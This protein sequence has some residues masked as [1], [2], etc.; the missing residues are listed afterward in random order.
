[1]RRIAFVVFALFCA[2]SAFAQG[3]NSGTITGT[4]TDP[5][6]ATIAGASVE[7][8]NKVTGYDKTTTTDAMG[9]FRFLG[10]PENNYH[11][12][13]KSPGFQDHVEDIMVRT[14]VPVNLA[15]AMK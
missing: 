15:V 6:G 4:V 10:V 9:A 1:M 11:T 12:E 14:T 3:I 5:S 2:I 7:I 8:Q 13:I